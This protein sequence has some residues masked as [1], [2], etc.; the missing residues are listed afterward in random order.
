MNIKFAIILALLTSSIFC[1]EL[2]AKNNDGIPNPIN[3]GDYDLTLANQRPDG[4]YPSNNNYNTSLTQSGRGGDYPIQVARHHI[5]PYARLR[6][7]FNRVVANGKLQYLNQFFNGMAS[8]V[9]DYAEQAWK[10]CD[11]NQDSHLRGALDAENVYIAIQ[12]RVARP[13]GSTSLQ[14][15]DYAATW[16]AWIPGNIF[17]GPATNFRSDDPGEE[18]FEVNAGTVVGDEAFSLLQSINADME[19]YLNNGNIGILQ[20]ISSNLR[21]LS[22]SRSSIY[23][24][25]S[26]NWVISG[27]GQNGLP[28][29][30]LK[31]YK[32]GPT[33]ATTS[34]NKKS[35]SVTCDNSMYNARIIGPYTA[36]FFS[37]INN[38]LLDTPNDNDEQ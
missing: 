14:Q 18:G 22:E 7:F 31:R 33:I 2:L 20:R 35:L 30:R 26:N 13:G 12:F 10:I 6:D 19:A 25:N 11:A 16:Y 24:L 15:F 4:P 17:L 3:P 28:I 38:L 9:A 36:S 27:Y 34:L 5:I 32:S 8:N 21:L 29:Y 23:D 37:G 1:R